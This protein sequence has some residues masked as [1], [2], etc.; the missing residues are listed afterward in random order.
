MKKIIHVRQK[1]NENVKCQNIRVYIICFKNLNKFFFQ[2][3]FFLKSI[4]TYNILYKF[5][6]IFVFDQIF[7]EQNKNLC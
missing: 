4:K 5:Y 7:I 6:F 2:N 3:Y 1:E